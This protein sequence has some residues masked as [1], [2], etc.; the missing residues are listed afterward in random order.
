M[1]QVVPCRKAG[2][3]TV[4]SRGH[5][6]RHVARHNARQGDVRIDGA[7]V[8]STCT[9]LAKPTICLRI[10]GQAGLDV[11]LAGVAGR[12]GTPAPRGVKRSEASEQ[13]LARRRSGFAATAG[14]SDVPRPARQG[15]AL[16]IVFSVVDGSDTAEALL[17]AVCNW[18]TSGGVPRKDERRPA[19]VRW[20]RVL[21]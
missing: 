13:S 3:A 2:A 20:V 17:E 7:R 21:T 6:D 8:W 11:R 18:E 5:H 12:D 19:V 16:A 15:Q 14:T 4:V 10:A 9:G 1:H